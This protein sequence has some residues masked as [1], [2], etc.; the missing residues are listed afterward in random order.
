MSLEIKDGDVVI[1]K[2][3]QDAE[4]GDIVVALVNGDDAVCKKLKHYDGMIMLLSVNPKYD[5]ITSNEAP[6]R[7]IGKVIEN[8]RTY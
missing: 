4:T 6:I 1:V 8:R 3:T 2:Q 5:P 7:I